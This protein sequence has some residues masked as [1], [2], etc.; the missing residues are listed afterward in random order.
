M[1]R[2]D[3]PTDPQQGFSN[4]NS[5]GIAIRN[6]AS[7]TLSFRPPVANFSGSMTHYPEHTTTGTNDFCDSLEFLAA[8]HNLLP[9]EISELKLHIPLPA[10]FSYVSHPLAKMQVKLGDGGVWGDQHSL[11]YS[12]TSIN[13]T[14]FP[15]TTK[16]G[17]YGSST[18]SAY[19][20]FWL[21]IACGAENR[22]QITGRFSGKSGCTAE[23]PKMYSSAPILIDGLPELTSYYVASILTSPKPIYTGT[24]APNK[25]GSFTVEGYYNRKGGA[26]LSDMQAIVE[27]PPNLTMAN[28]SGNA[29]DSLSFTESVT[30][31]GAR[32][33]IAILSKD[34][35]FDK[36]RYFKLKLKPV[37]PELWHEDTVQIKFHSGVEQPMQ[38]SGQTC[39]VLNISDTLRTVKFAMQMLHLRY[40]DSIARSR[41]ASGTSEH[42]EISGKL[43]ND[44]VNSA[45]DAKTLTME[46][47]TRTGSSYTP[48]S[49]PL[50]GDATINSVAAGQSVSFTVAADIPY[51][52][53]V[54]NLWLVLRKTGAGASNAYLADSVV[55][56]VPNPQYEILSQH[57]PFC[58][59]ES[60][61]SVGEA[62]IT[63]YTYQWSPLGFTENYLSATNTTPV[64]FTYDYL[65]NPI[66]KDT[67]L[68]YLV[69]LTRPGGGVCASTD[70]ILVPMKG[71]P[72]VN[73]VGNK[74]V[75]DGKKLTV[76]FAD[77]TNTNPV[78]N[79]TTF[80]WKV[81]SVSGGTI[82]GLPTV[83]V[84]NNGDIDLSLTNSGTAPASAVISVTPRKNG[85]DGVP[86]TFTVTVNPTPKLSSTL[87]PAAICSG[88]P[89]SYIA[90][91]ETSGTTF[92]W[93]RAAVPG[94]SPN[95]GAGSS[96]TVN[97]TLTNSTAN[98]LT[99]I[100]LFTLS[101]N[102]C[103]NTQTVT[104]VVKPTP[105]LNSGLTPAAICSG[106]TF[107]YVAGSATSGTTFS[108]T[109]AAIT[110][111]S[112]ATG[113]GSSANVSETL[114]NSTADPIEVRYV[115]TLT[116]DDC[117]N[118][119]EVTVR[120]YG[121]LDGGS[122]AADQTIC[123]GKVP[124]KLTSLSPATGGSTGTSTY[125]WQESTN[126][127]TTWTLSGSSE[128][129]YAPPAL[130]QTTQYRRMVTNDCGTEFSDTVT[131]T[132][133]HQSL[134]NYP[135]LRIR[136]CPDGVDVNLSKYVDTLDLTGTPTWSGAGIGT[137][138]GIIPANVLDSHNS[139]LT[140]TYTV[141]NP[142][143]SNIT[144][145][146]Y[147]EVLKTGRMRPLRDTVVICADNADGINVNQIFGIDAGKGTW[148]YLS[149]SPNDIKTYVT[150]SHSSTYGGA[151]V[152][153][154]K[155][156]YGSL[157][158]VIAPITYNGGKAKKAVFT[159]T[160]A[161]DSCL[162]G[163]AYQIV[164][165]L[166]GN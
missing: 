99:V 74:S 37:H 38:C 16:L 45:F 53:D 133:R 152:L 28:S 50:T 139:V 14:L 124:D 156:L 158:S 47:C 42:V 44:G 164:I 138:T 125:Y 33:L 10:G 11:S 12:A 25:D 92:S 166:T 105:T 85:C 54:C 32:R 73:S 98:P 94:I 95:T 22:R 149:H 17:A 148:T 8:Y 34:D 155:A 27:L 3:Y 6:T 58:Q 80:R 5:A 117:S 137:A 140:F 19:V 112:P 103:S 60:N 4:Y 9:T 56:K 120:V 106:M 116:A 61:V 114:T 1:S 39:N 126:N 150:E 81:V 83:G 84:E 41:R 111:I 161:T 30:S 52:I 78:G 93:T 20:R 134:Y 63:D 36:N 121:K 153:N 118:S 147:V 157:D 129:E 163:K 55:M 104:V 108:W 35:P 91:S 46:L 136:V 21:K 143:R 130:M 24:S 100:Y 89:F 59:T 43:V 159:Y 101:A 69:T 123:H 122:I 31:T 165:I 2:S 48:V 154:G 23:I 141:S 79:P 66:A 144:R 70:T 145:K 77:A 102:G 162:G 119:Q 40:S 75:C 128:E 110:G 67:V 76:A 18:A 109:R 131:V 142:C 96:G 97:E 132:V 49:V 107:T 160:P 7:A 87:T 65:S 113:S 15:A 86:K 135:D 146:V 29:P 115:F 82:G 88:T 151:V 72:S 127:G 62:P 64:N 71:I 68:K 51:T 26:S 90:T 57:A 13:A